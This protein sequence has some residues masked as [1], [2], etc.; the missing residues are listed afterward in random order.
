M[1]G[2][3]TSEVTVSGWSEKWNKIIY[4]LNFCKC[5]SCVCAAISYFRTLG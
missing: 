3:I 2:E 4:G 5:Q 1:G